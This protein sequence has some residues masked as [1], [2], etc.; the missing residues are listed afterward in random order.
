MLL[1]GF[2]ARGRDER[3]AEPPR[4]FGAVREGLCDTARVEGAGMSEAMALVE[5]EV[6]RELEQRRQ[7]YG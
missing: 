5:A 6:L 3:D 1:H 7:A 4:F 2:L